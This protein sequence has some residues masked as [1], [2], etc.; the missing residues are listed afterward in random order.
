MTEEDR[1]AVLCAALKAAITA[2]LC[3]VGAGKRSFFTPLKR[4]STFDSGEKLI[5]DSNKLSRGFIPGIHYRSTQN[6]SIEANLVK[7]NH[8]RNH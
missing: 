6:L 2:L 7:I 4:I 3:L 1:S 8:F 5:H